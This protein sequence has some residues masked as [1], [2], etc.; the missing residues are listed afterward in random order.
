MTR[1]SKEPPAIAVRVSVNGQWREVPG[2]TRVDSL[3]RELGV[4][5]PRVA[6]EYNAEILPR[7][8]YADTVLKDGDRIEIVTF[9][10]GG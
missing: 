9:V 3:L 2:D 6:V 7:P 8:Q 5:T 1:N 4:G 10:G